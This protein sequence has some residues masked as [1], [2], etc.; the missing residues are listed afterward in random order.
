MSINRKVIAVAGIAALTVSA[1]AKVGVDTLRRQKSDAAAKR[2]LRLLSGAN[3][4]PQSQAGGP[5]G[6]DWQI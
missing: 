2:S 1:F 4:V 6:G 5:A 3:L